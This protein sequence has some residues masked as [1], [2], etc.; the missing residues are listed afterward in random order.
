[1]RLSTEAAGRRKPKARRLRAEGSRLLEHC[2][3]LWLCLAFVVPV[4]V[5]AETGDELRN[6]LPQDP[7]IQ[8]R[9][10]PNGMRYWIR[11]NTGPAGKISLWL[12]IG[13][14]S[15]NED[16]DQRGLAHLLEHMAFNGSENFPV[17]TLVKRFESAGLTFGAH[18]NA[19]TSFI[20]TNYKLT[21]PNDAKVLD[22]GLL[23]FADI[24]YR[25][26]LDPAEITRESRVVEAERRARDDAAARVF[27]RQL[28]ALVPGSRVGARLPIGDERTVREATSEHLRAY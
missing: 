17:G 12:R 4:A 21:I 26:T 27:N 7:S 28:A 20:D 24:A 6:P 10:L 22:L 19:T 14:G 1:M 25:L 23:Y 15:L 3:R 8:Y 5:L 9:V 11:P 16:D 18:Q 13:S 2:V